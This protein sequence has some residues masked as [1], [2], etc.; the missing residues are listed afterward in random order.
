M[1]SRSH[2]RTLKLTAACVAI[3]TAPLAAQLPAVSLDASLGGNSRARRAAISAWHPLLRIAGRL[4]VGLGA[5]LSAYGGEPANYTNRG[6]A[7]GNLAPST[8]ID[9]A[10]YAVN[11]AAFGELRLA[12]HV[13]LGANLDL[14]GVAAGPERTTGTLTAKPQ[15]LSYFRYG[16]ADHGA[17][18]SEF[19]VALRVAP[20]VRIRA[21]LS[22]YVIDY[23]VTDAAVAGTPSSRY[24]QFQTV[25]FVAVAFQPSRD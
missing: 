4:Q 12:R 14:V 8:T 20:R 10:V 22:H 5:R 18:N 13:A 21:G 17:L 15:A 1:T 25:P 6:A 7:Q 16:S 23:I 19:F 3:L 24:Q 2:T 9:P 11:A